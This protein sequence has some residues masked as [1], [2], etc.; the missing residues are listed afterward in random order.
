MLL[1]LA[2]DKACFR[3][4]VERLVVTNPFAR[5]ILRPQSFLLALD[6]VLDHTTGNI[7][8]VLRRT[9]ILFQPYYLRRWEV[10][11]KLQDVLNVGATP[12]IN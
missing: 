9:I 11:L 12:A 4:G 1:N 7:E 5:R 10:L 3:F 6:I 2:G 8:N